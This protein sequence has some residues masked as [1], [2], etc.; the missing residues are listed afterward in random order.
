MITKLRDNLYVSGM[1]E[2]SD[3]QIIHD[4][5]ITAILN[6]AY[7]VDLP[8]WPPQK[9]RQVK[10]GMADNNE[11]PES[12][13]ELAVDTAEKLL[14]SGEKLLINCAAGW[15]RSIYTCVMVLSRQDGEDWHNV[16]EEVQKLHP[17]ALIGPLFTNQN[18]YY[19]LLEKESNEKK[20]PKLENVAKG[21]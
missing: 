18:Q 10:V 8:V 6:V 21:D 13:K 7:E 1:K 11:N 9:V 2:A 19:R 15:S 14:N 12:L 5:G 4:L 16:Y 20:D 17:F 3:P